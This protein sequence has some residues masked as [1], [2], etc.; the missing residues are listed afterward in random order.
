MPAGDF[1]NSSGV[2][3]TDQWLTTVPA[4]N[5]GSDT[6]SQTRKEQHQ[7]SN[8]SSSYLHRSSWDGCRDVSS[9]W[10]S[11]TKPGQKKKEIIKPDLT[12]E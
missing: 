6:K 11:L 3:Q 4:V 12:T 9:L 1:C 7:V 8:S 5:Q 2:Q 10:I